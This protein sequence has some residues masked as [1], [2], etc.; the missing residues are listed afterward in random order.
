MANE[1]EGSM[2][3]GNERTISYR[4]WR[5]CRENTPNV[6]AGIMSESCAN[7]TPLVIPPTDHLSDT[8]GFPLN[9][10]TGVAFE[11]SPEVVNM[12]S[13]GYRWNGNAYVRTPL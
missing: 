1:K 9:Q 4:G 11:I 5:L 7:G 13:S 12:E 10:T 3:K 2:T 8:S 6:F